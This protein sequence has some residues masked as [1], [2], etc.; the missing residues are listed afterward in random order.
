MLKT[1][2]TLD[3]EP[4]PPEIV[5]AYVASWN[6]KNRKKEERG[7]NSGY[8]K[9]V[10]AY[11]ITL[12]GKGYTGS[13]WGAGYTEYQEPTLAMGVLR[14]LS[15]VPT[16]TIIHIY[17][18]SQLGKYI[19]CGGW[20]RTNK[21]IEGIK[22]FEAIIPALDKYRWRYFPIDKHCTASEY[23]KAQR[24]VEQHAQPAAMR[25]WRE[26]DPTA[27]RGARFE[28]IETDANPNP[29]SNIGG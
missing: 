23:L 28:I 27:K 12:I 21:K 10:G 16:G 2:L 20:A 5:T 7:R 1:P 24:I 9:D 18:H 13:F 4:I 17:T 11:G 8:T 6:Y 14:V 22:T 3:G 15:L 26:F 19:T 25:L 29:F